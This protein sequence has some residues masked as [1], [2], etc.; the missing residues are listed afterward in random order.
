MSKRFRNNLIIL[1]I[2]VATVYI[3]VRG[4]T[5]AVEYFADKAYQKRVSEEHFTEVDTYKLSVYSEEN[6]EAVLKALKSGDKEALEKLF[7]ESVDAAA[8]M[9]YADWSTIND[10]KTKTLGGGS[11]MFEPDKSGRMDFGET[12]WVT[13]SK[14]TYVL[15][16]QTVCSRFGKANDG[17]SAVAATT[18]EHYDSIDWLWKW[19]TDKNE[20]LAG[21]PYPDK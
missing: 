8:L 13:T 21:T 5:F 4:F 7:T 11:Y 6:A 15:Y 12:F 14:G 19:Q 3:S 1:L 20:V 9:K 17:V 2:L 18:W 10:K 16:I